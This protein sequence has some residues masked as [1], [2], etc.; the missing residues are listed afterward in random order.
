MAELREVAAILDSGKIDEEMLQS[1]LQALLFHQ[2]LYED[3]PHAQAYRIIARHLSNVQP[4]VGAFGYRVTHHPVSNMIVLQSS[5][6]VYG[7]QLA[8]LKKDETT[9]LLVLR[10]LYAEG[11]SSLDEYGRVEITTDDVHDRLRA[12]GDEPPP[13]QRLS[14]ILKMFHRKGLVKIGDR[15]PVEQLIVLTIMP[16]ITVLVPDVYVEALVQWLEERSEDASP[17]AG[18]LGIATLRNREAEPRLEAAEEDNV[19]EDDPIVNEQRLED[20]D[21]SA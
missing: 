10:L 7:T 19:G 3:W 5:G 8:R 2:C 6:V 13:M 20:D 17:P 14:E 9:V 1:A 18:I 15:D 4:I 11:V 12:A 16:G 21:A